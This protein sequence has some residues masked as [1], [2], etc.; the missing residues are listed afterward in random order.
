GLGRR[1]DRLP[2]AAA[3]TPQLSFG[4]PAR[5]RP[6]GAV[7]VR[8]PG[9][10]PEPAVARAAPRGHAGR[11]GGP[12]RHPPV[13]RAPRELLPGQAREPGRSRRAGREPEAVL[14]GDEPAAGVSGYFT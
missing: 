4:R 7:G 14:G 8:G 12:G 1:D 10:D 9:V 6:P 3:R 5:R 2:V 11:L 13:L